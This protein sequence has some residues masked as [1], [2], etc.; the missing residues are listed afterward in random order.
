[1][2]K[3]NRV[4]VNGH[5]QFRRFNLSEAWEI[6]WQQ[7]D[8]LVLLTITLFLFLV[9]KMTPYLAEVG[10]VVSPYFKKIIICLNLWVRVTSVLE[11]L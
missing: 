1:V 3:L 9:M 4:A 10:V 11:D 5:N 2:C 7:V 8:V 6:G